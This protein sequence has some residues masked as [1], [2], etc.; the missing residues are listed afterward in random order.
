MYINSRD[1]K[2]CEELDMNGKIMSHEKYLE[3]LTTKDVD[4]CCNNIIT[5]V[6]EVF[7]EVAPIKKNKNK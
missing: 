4:K 7:N 5:I 1:L 3:T 6:N 2:N